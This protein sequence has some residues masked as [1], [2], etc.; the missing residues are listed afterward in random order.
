MVHQSP[1]VVLPRAYWYAVSLAVLVVGIGLAYRQIKHSGDAV[2]GEARPV[3]GRGEIQIDRAGSYS[4]YVYR[5]ASQR[6]DGA[7][8]QA[9]S[10]AEHAQVSVRGGDGKSL[11]IKKVYETIE[12][13]NTRVAR[14]VEFEV[15]ASGTY[16]VEVA[17][18]LEAVKPVVRPSA[19]VAK[20]GDEVMG[21]VVG[22]LAGLAIGA[23]ATIGAVVMFVVVLL[24]RKK[25]KRE[26]A[27]ARR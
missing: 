12:L 16:R 25:F 18:S 1:P 15:P 4:L 27:L 5:G 10:A 7:A 6:M 17:P 19:P 24:K 3:R 13:Q 21:V 20:F 23:I 26:L 2:S 22:A 14:L 8:D 9:W 11:A